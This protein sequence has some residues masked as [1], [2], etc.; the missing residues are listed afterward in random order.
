MKSTKVIDSVHGRILWS[1]L[2][3]NLLI[4]KETL[5]QAISNKLKLHY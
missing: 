5:L 3:H 1:L 4:K 2:L